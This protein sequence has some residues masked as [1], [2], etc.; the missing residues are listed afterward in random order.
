MVT[1]FFTNI[2]QQI[3]NELKTAKTDIKVAVCWFTCKELFDVLYEKLKNNIP[4]TVIIL[5]DSINNRTDG[6]N[7]QL[8]IDTGGTFYFGDVENPMHNKYCIID[9]EILINGS[10][11]WTYFAETK[12]FENITIFKS[13]EY[14]VKDFINDFT[15]LKENCKLVT[16]VAKDANKDIKQV[17]V[18]EN[19]QLASDTDLV[20]KGTKNIGKGQLS[21]T[22]ALGEN[23]YQDVYFTVIPKGSK[24][25]ISK[26]HI[27][28]TVSND[29][30]ICN[31]DIRFGENLQGSLNTHVGS[32]TIIDIPP[33]PKGTAGLITNFSVDEYGIL[34]IS[35]TV[36]ETGNVTIHKFNIE[37]LVQ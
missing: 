25:P 27:F 20:I 8:F 34:T 30:I 33:L 14:I 16:D 2:R 6:L 36:R 32:F 4:V 23:T 15:R 9:N 24:V 31:K 22:S 26:T 7:F 1:P 19:T 37:H 17:T 3:I 21:L 13:D 18:V 12:N 11:N 5:N 29:Q 28:T 35:V 10:Y